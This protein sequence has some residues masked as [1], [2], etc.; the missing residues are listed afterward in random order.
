MGKY[1]DE[2]FKIATQ[3][4]DAGDWARATA[5]R[6]KTNYAIKRFK[7]DFFKDRI[8]NS[9]GD[10]K[11]FWENISCLLPKKSGNTVGDIFDTV[12]GKLLTGANAAD[13]VNRYF[14]KL[15]RN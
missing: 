12:T 3:T 11:K 8:L 10:P 5:Q 7:R 15:E 6:Q 4:K 13:F 2:L 9:K 1:R 14:V